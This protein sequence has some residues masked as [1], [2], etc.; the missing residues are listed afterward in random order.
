M[1]I[2]TYATIKAHIADMAWSEVTAAQIDANFFPQ[3]QAKMYYGDRTTMP[4]IP[5][6]RIRQ[7][8]ATGTLTPDS[9]GEVT[10]SSEVATGWLEF[11]ELTPTYT[12]AKSMNFVEP[13]R[14]R[15]ET[16]LLGATVSPQYIYTVEGDSLLV[17]PKSVGTIVAAWYQKFTALSDDADTDW[18]LLNAPHAYI[19]GCM[20]EICSYLQDDREAEF[21]AKFAGAIAG[22]NKN[23]EMVRSS[24]APL[25]ARPRVVV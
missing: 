20:A 2:N 5:P 11:I 10:I 6:L 13:W 24:G 23:D 15:K 9:G 14:F 8:V 19:N 1:A 12:D 25:L 17:A 21:R 4:V 7:M 3:M 18:A 16:T 22:L